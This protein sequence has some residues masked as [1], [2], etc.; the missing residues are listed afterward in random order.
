M[1]HNRRLRDQNTVFN[2]ALTMSMVTVQATIGSTALQAR[3][4][5]VSGNFFE[6]LGVSPIV[7]RLLSPADDQI[8][9]AADS[10]LAVIG[11]KL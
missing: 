7:G 8:N 10:T 11:Y 4:R 2:S 1:V 6:T 5:F 9:G 3:G